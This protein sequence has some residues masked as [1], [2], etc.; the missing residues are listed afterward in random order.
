VSDPVAVNH[1]ADGPPD[2]PVV[3]LAHAI[4]TSLAMWEPQAEVLSGVFRVV[5]YDQRGHGGSPV[6]AGPYEIADLGRDLLKLMDGLRVERASLCG[7]SLGAM[8]VLW[9]AAHAPDRVERLVACCVSAR[10]V[11]PEAWAERAATVRRDGIAAIEELVVDR[12]GYRD[13]NPGIE[14]QVRAMLLATPPA[15]YAACCEAIRTMNLEPD[16]GSIAAPTMLLAG[17]DDPAAPPAA[18]E[19]VARMIPGSTLR[20][21]DGAAHLANVEQ[22]QAVTAAI[23]EHLAPILAGRRT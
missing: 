19:S 22:P 5:R 17:A 13:R 8:T 4:G 3:I 18:M 7:L 14:A 1:V 6:P 12:W 15:G 20:V 23:S 11:S 16:L 9:V 2:A 10:P 21:V